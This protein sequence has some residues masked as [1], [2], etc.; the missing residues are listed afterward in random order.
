MG[1]VD[2][3]GKLRPVVQAALPLAQVK[4]ALALSHSRHA[5]GKIILTI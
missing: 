3:D 5:G 4:E 1:K 2:D